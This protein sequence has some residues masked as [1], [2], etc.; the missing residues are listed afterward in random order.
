MMRTVFISYSSTD[1]EFVDRLSSDLKILGLGVWLD[2]WEIKVG[3]SIISKVNDGLARNDYLIVVLSPDSIN[4]NW[5]RKEVFSI[6][7]SEINSGKVK[8]LPVLYKQCEVPILLLDKKYA[9]FSISYDKGLEELAQSVA[10]EEN[11]NSFKLREQLSSFYVKKAIQYEECEDLEE[12]LDNYNK[13][14]QA[15]PD[16]VDAYYNFG[17]FLS[18]VG[19]LTEAQGAYESALLRNPDHALSLHNLGAIYLDQGKYQEA[20]GCFSKNLSNG[21]NDYG[22]YRM[23]GSTYLDMSEEEEAI[24]L[25][26]KG[27]KIAPNL[28]EYST[29]CFLLGTAYT[30]LNY[31]GHAIAYLEEFIDAEAKIGRRDIRNYIGISRKFIDINFYERAAEY[32]KQGLLINSTNQEILDLQ[33]EIQGEDTFMIGFA[34]S[35]TSMM[36][37]EIGRYEYRKNNLF[38]GLKTYD[39]FSS[40]PVF[41]G[42]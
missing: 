2:R 21:I 35:G 30:R 7:M 17:V 26:A 12:A 8:I 22:S 1:K 38:E 20:V 3:D 27:L 36:N 28:E 32:I 14:I 4:S 9:D 29:T 41:I 42:K 11:N 23:L 24:E 13:A 34:R 19:N 16:N 33:K 25:L 40:V 39:G 6:L 10:S 5:V 37:V 31:K 18:Y 15:D